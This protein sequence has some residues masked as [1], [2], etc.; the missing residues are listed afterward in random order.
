MVRITSGEHTTEFVQ[1]QGI[2]P[3]KTN[4]KPAVWVMSLLRARDHLTGAS[5]SH[6]MDQLIDGYGT[7]SALTELLDEFDFYFLPVAN[8]DGYTHSYSGGDRFWSKNRSPNS[9]GCAGTDLSRNFPHGGWSSTGIADSQIGD[10]SSNLF[11][12]DIPQVSIGEGPPSYDG[13]GSI[14]SGTA[15][16]GSGS[17][18]WDRWPRPLLLL[19][20]GGTLLL[21]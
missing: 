7:D 4:G 10:G 14:C 1:G 5:L 20:C 18:F 3:S 8:P 6:L 21:L 13:A 11:S 17:V 2:V 19:L 15:F 9:N 12:L 16:T